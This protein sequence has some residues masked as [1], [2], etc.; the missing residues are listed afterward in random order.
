MGGSSRKILITGSSGFLGKK[1]TE[2]FAKHHPETEIRLLIHKKIPVATPS[3]CQLIKGSLEDGA[4]L[5]KALT[6]IHTVVHFAGKTHTNKEEEYFR[7]NAAGTKTLAEAA[8]EAG[9]TRFI[10]ISTRAI[11]KECGDYA[12]SKRRAE[13]A[14]QESGIPYSILR[15]SEIYGEDSKEGLGFL[16]KIISSSLPIIPYPAGNIKLAPL[17]L[18]DAIQ[19]ITNAVLQ[20]DLNDKIYNLAGPRSYP[21]KEVIRIIAQS[22]SRKKIFLPIPLL[23][24]RLAALIKINGRPIAYDDQINRLLCQKENNIDAA[25]HDLHFSPRPFE[26]GLSYI[27]P[28]N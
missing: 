11:K 8:Q 12:V 24:F 9:V 13:E 28:R 15:L 20:T 16:I 19:G 25:R 10:F 6:G 21:I 5:K 17:L 1:F 4:S 27:Y 22:F 7:V 2:Y 3:N 23:A 14:V 18:E 26:D